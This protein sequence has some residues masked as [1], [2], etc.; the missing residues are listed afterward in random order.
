MSLV[1]FST[2]WELELA[3]GIWT[4]AVAIVN[5]AEA[6]DSSVAAAVV[7]TTVCY[8]RMVV[9][10]VDV[11][12][13]VDERRVIAVAMVAVGDDMFEMETRQNLP[14]VGAVGIAGVVELLVAVDFD[15]HFHFHFRLAAVAAAVSDPTIPDDCS[16]LLKV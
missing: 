11:A 6:A 8:G 7:G 2:T 15:P 10:V 16:I 12:V 5:S 14:V 9:A 3:S 13:F 1:A 4:A